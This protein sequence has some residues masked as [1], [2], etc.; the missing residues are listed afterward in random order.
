MPFA[1]PICLEEDAVSR[2]VQEPKMIKVVPVIAAA[3]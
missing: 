1:F 2:A 3:R